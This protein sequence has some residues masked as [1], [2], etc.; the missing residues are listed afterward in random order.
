MVKLNVTCK[1]C[2]RTIEVDGVKAAA[3]LLEHGCAYCREAARR[4]AQRQAQRA[5]PNAPPP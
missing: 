2:G 1:K 3:H 5:Q 4:D